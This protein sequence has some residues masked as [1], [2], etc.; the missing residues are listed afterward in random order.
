MLLLS[1]EFCSFIISDAFITETCVN[2]P[3]AVIYVYPT[4]FALA[5]PVCGFID[6]ISEFEDYQWG[7]LT[8][9]AEKWI[10]PPVWT[11]G[12]AGLIMTP[13]LSGIISIAFIPSI[14]RNNK[15]FPALFPWIII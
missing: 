13:I 12:N 6:I 9:G 14:D 8:S 5:Y 15:Q 2:I 10:M 3:L 7:L 1:I 4:E 11:T